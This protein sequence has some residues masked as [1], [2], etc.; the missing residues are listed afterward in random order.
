MVWYSMVWYGI[1]WY[2]MVWYKSLFRN[3]HMQ[4][5]TAI[6]SIVEKSIEFIAYSLLQMS[7]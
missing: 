1:L 7:L 2:G 6:V 3:Q 5:K 4:V